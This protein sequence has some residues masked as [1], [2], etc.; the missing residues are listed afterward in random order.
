MPCAARCRD[1]STPAA[2]G[3]YPTE[4]IDVWHSRDRER[5]TLRPVLPQDVGFL[6]GLIRWLAPAARYNS[7]HGAVGELP[8]EVLRDM[9]QVNYTQCLALAITSRESEGEIM[10]V[11]ARYVVDDSG[12]SAEVALMVDDRWQRK[13]PGRVGDARARHRTCRVPLMQFVAA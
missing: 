13:G 2:V 10:V 5:L 12:R 11:D 8:C 4:L 7:F 1:G 9:T 3:H 6:D